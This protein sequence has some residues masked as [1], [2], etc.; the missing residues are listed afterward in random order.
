MA[1]TQNRGGEYRRMLLEQRGQRGISAEPAEASG[2][3]RIRFYICLCLFIGYLILDYTKASLYTLDSSR[4]YAEICRDMTADLNLEETFA[5]MMDSIWVSEPAK[6][7]T[8]P[9]KEL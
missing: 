3:F 6:E 4:I 5:N 2:I 7:E 9:L 1:K 8:E